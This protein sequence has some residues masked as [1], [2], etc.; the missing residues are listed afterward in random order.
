M[1][2]LVFLFISSVFILVSCA[3]AKKEKG[4]EVKTI[5]TEKK[6]EAKIAEVDPIAGKKLFGSKGCTA[7]HH[8]TAKIIGP[9]VKV[10]AAGYT[11][12]NGDVL[13]FLKGKSE[14]II[15]T[16]PT[17]ISIMKNNVETM[18]KDISN[19]DLI[20]IVAYINSVK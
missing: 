11:A 16:D 3:D 2:K 8:E 20:N 13:K 10:I 9:A 19:T 1:K 7:C 14:A 12:K 5:K 15:D 4:S 18:V 17:N 6:V